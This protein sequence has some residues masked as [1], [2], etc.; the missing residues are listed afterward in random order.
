MAEVVAVVASGAG[1]ASLAIQLAEGA[2]KFR[3][4]HENTR[5]LHSDVAILIEDL[6]VI[7]MQLNDLETVTDG[8]LEQQMGPIILE[9]CR[10]QSQFRELY[11]SDP[12]FINQVDPRGCGYL[13]KAVSHGPWGMAGMDFENQTQLLRLFVKEFHLS[14]GLESSGCASFNKE[15]CHL[16]IIEALVDLGCDFSTTASP[17]FESWPKPCIDD[18][19]F[20]AFHRIIP[21]DPFYVDYLGVVLK[22]NPD[23]GD[24][25]PIHSAIIYRSEGEFQRLVQESR[26]LEDNVN[27]LGQSPLHIAVRYPSRLVTLLAAGHDV[28]VRDKN[29]ITP[30]MYAAA[31]NIPEAYKISDENEEEEDRFWDVSTQLKLDGIEDKMSDWLARDYPNIKLGLMIH[32]QQRQSVKK[33]EIESKKEKK[34][35]SA[36]SLHH[37]PARFEINMEED[38]MYSIL[39]LMLTQ[40]GAFF[41]SDLLG[42]E[43]DYTKQSLDSFVNELRNARGEKFSSR[44]PLIAE[45]SAVF[46]EF[47]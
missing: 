24:S 36:P 13:E 33:A 32:L 10:S 20:T 19:S 21:E 14:K 6:G 35:E 45:L 2:H 3:Q 47:C 22:S 28:G 41:G 30:L 4:R 1:L 44:L 25:P 8:I 43:E 12:A 42:E 27:F 5:R 34:R 46:A 40:P 11:K 31:M 37:G 15:S 17:N 29:G 16:A 38:E 26:Y 39:D 9:R 23:F 7:I 18:Q